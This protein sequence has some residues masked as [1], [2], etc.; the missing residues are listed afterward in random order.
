MEP[1]CKIHCTKHHRECPLT[2]GSG[3]AYAVKVGERRDGFWHSEESEPDGVRYSPHGTILASGIITE[4]F[5]RTPFKIHHL[6]PLRFGKGRKKVFH[7]SVCHHRLF[8]DIFFF[9]QAK[10]TG[11]FSMGRNGN[12]TP[13][14]RRPACIIRMG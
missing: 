2:E 3:I 7:H 1:F 14:G 13:T 11:G 9:R 6:I 10:P 12:R 8:T 4:S 5:W